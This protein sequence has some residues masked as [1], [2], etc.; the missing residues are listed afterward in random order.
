MAL[1]RQMLGR[2][3]PMDRLVF[4]LPIPDYVELNRR[5][6]N[7]M[8]YFAHIWRLGR[9]QRQDA[10]GRLHYIDGM[11]K[12]PE[13]LENIWFPDLDLLQRRLEELLNRLEGTGMGVVCGTQS[14]P[15]V[16]ATAMGIEDFWVNSKWNVEFVEEFIRIIQDWCLRELEAYLRFP[17]EVIKVGSGFVTKTGPMCSP[18]MLERLET[19]YLRQQVQMAR[20]HGKLVFHHIDGN[21]TSMVPDLIHMGVDILNPIEPCAGLQDIYEIK[22]K[23]GDRV[24]LCGNIDVD[25]VLFR[26]SPEE[27]ARDVQ[28]HIERL[29]GGGG[30]ICASSHDLHQ[31][32]PID[33]FYAM[34]DAVHQYRF[35]RRS[36]SGQG[37]SPASQ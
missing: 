13:D 11:I 19:R 3:L 12:R 4:E 1:A 9:K 33:N 28:E 6:G 36:A 15:F 37:A 22:A 2:D 21:I 31:L 7:D 14:A 34:R 35:R 5:M 10:E 23:Y 26:G 29:A 20:E 18:A 8:I 24:A 30:Y 27:V 16:A 17:V 32:I 25:G